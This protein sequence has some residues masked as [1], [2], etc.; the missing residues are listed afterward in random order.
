MVPASKS[1]NYHKHY[2]AF[3]L[4]TSPFGHEFLYFPSACCAIPIK[5][6]LMLYTKTKTL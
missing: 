1:A 6:A 5:E 3:L 2:K 4:Q